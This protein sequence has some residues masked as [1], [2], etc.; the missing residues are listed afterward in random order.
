MDR[1]AIDKWLERA[2]LGLV[3]VF[4]VFGPL[5]FGAV[6]PSEFVVLQW[7]LLGAVALW[8]LRT[9]IAPRYRFLLPPPVWA[10]V[11]F[12]LYGVWRYRTADIEYLARQEFIQALMAAILFVVLVNNLYGQGNIRAIIVCLAAVGTLVAMYG[13]YQWLTGSEQVWHL[14][15][16]AYQGR[17]SG[18]FVC[19]NHLAGFLEMICPL[20]ITATALRG[21]G[22]VAR[23]FFGYASLVMLIGIATTASRAGWLAA[24]VSLSV[25]AGCLIRRRGHIWAALAVLLLVGAVGATFYERVMKPRLFPY[26][27]PSKMETDDIRYVLWKSAKQMW[28][29]HPWVGV[30]PDHF[31]HRY[32]GYRMANWTTQMRPGR[33]HNDYWNTLADWGLIGLTLVLLP[34]VVVG[35]G[36]VIFWRYLKRAGETAGSR[37]SV[38][39]GSAIGILSI[40]VHSFF[41]FNMHVPANAFVAT[42]LLALMAAHWRFASQKFWIASRWPVRIAGTALLGGCAFFLGAQTWRHTGEVL[43][44][45][46]AEAAPSASAERVEA[47]RKAFAIEPKNADTAQAIGEQ[48]RLQSWAGE[49]GH[50]AQALEAVEWFQRAAA[51]NPWDPHA[52]LGAGMCLDWID[53]PAEAEPYFERALKL[54]PNHSHTRAM[55]GWHYFQTERFP[56]TVSWM[57]RAL[58]LNAYDPTATTYL[59]LAKKILAGQASAEL[60]RPLPAGR[61]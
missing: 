2:A 21:F 9:W 35:A 4:L 47:L 5:S 40:L 26:Y 41:D 46:K 7:L 45:R 23:I 53:R 38:V 28:T 43:A 33:A 50:E 31:D 14:R 24:A 27:S 16:P 57:E 51:L 55:M 30:G 29:E 52:P 10:I 42:T 15:R 3:L 61:P 12:I 20:A 32:R 18:T 13:I 19:P 39:L 48:L 58:E 44:L 56:E 60:D 54:D 25:L 11:P 17:G 34:V 59:Q 49:P 37:V 36:V 1:E 22:A 8:L 6:R